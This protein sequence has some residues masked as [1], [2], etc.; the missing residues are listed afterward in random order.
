VKK[1]S[2]CDLIADVLADGQP[3]RMEEI[4]QRVGFCRLNSRIAELRA[5]RGLNIVC[6]RAGG[7]YTYQLLSASRPE[8]AHVETP[9]G[10]L[11]M[12]VRA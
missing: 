10:Q 12:A 8:L 1:P 9:G 5:R 4:H 11:S 6:Q 3:H 7:V 2:Q